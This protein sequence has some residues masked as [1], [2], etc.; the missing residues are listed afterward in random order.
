[1]QC[2]ISIAIG[3]VGTRADG[4]IAAVSETDLEQHSA[5]MT[6]EPPVAEIGEVGLCYLSGVRCREAW[7][8]VSRDGGRPPSVGE[9]LRV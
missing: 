8:I 3:L 9:S 7:S 2:A 4:A 1:V 5:R 6:P